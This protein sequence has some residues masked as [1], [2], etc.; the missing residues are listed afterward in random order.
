M[1]NYPLSGLKPWAFLP[2]LKLLGFPH[3]RVNSC[4]HDDHPL[5]SL[6]DQGDVSCIMLC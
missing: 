2:A 4:D 6:S 1:Y 3:G 5:V